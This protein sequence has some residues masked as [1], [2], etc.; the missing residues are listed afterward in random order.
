MTK[1]IVDRPPS[2]AL[3]FG[4]R[5]PIWLYRLRLGWLLGNRFLMLTHTGRTSGKPRETV[6]E[7]VRHDKETD[8]YYVV[9]GWAEKSSWYQNIRKTPE[10]TIHVG[11]RKFQARAEFIPFTQ[12]KEIIEAYARENPTAFRELT[13]LFLGKRMESAQ[14]STRT[15][16]EKMPMVAF[17]PS[18]IV[19]SETTR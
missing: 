1:A 13:S 4:L 7:V 16:A 6:I 12:A 5:L 18:K 8:A 10:V 19:S 11:G 17:H 9:S 3:R 15:I 14:A 2:K